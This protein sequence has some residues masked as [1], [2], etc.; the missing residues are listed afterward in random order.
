MCSNEMVTRYKL[1][2][3]FFLFVHFTLGSVKFAIFGYFREKKKKK[4]PENE[5]F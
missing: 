5:F 2:N 1:A 4:E 3:G